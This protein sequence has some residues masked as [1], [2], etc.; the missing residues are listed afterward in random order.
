MKKQ[1]QDLVLDFKNYAFVLLAL[2]TFFYIGVFVESG[3]VSEQSTMMG[4]SAFM[5]AGA[6]ICF[7]ISLTFHKKLQKEAE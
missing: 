3:K 4:A 7:N 2:G 5:L 1:L 6:L